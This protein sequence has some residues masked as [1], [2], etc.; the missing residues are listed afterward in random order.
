MSRRLLVTGGAGYI[1]AHLVIDL[2]G[3][4]YDVV[5]VDDFSTGHPEA[6]VRAQRLANRRC[7]VHRGDVAD[8]ALMARALDGVDAVIHLA[9]YKMVGESMEQPE[10]YFRNNLGGMASLV[11]S[12][13]SAGVC[14][15]VYSSSAAVYGTQPNPLEAI[16]EDAPLR[17]ESPYGLSKAQG[18]Q[19]LDWM[20]QRRHW[21][22]VSLRYFNPV[23]A[24]PSGQI[25]QPPAGAANLLP[26]ALHALM[27]PG[28]ASARLSI[29][30]TDFPT[31][32][33]TGLRDY[34]HV[35]DLSRAHLAALD[36]LDRPGHQIF[37]VGTGRPHSVREVVAACQRVTGQPVPHLEAPRRPGDVVCALAAPHRI[38]R[39]LGFEARLGVDEMVASAWK[40]AA[41]NPDGYGRV[42]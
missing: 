22:A 2:L 25:G 32:D 34:I 39:A 6:L 18:E 42:T 10:R 33:G 16:D 19:V 30:G 26:R 36:A 38:Q 27:N 5:V 7:D 1:G 4:G 14:R 9:A 29:L 20:V 35:C 13:V 24:H 23:G 17:P 41:Q 37:N 15:M 3:A 8:P 11:A 12:M 28:T 31:P 40:W 21:S